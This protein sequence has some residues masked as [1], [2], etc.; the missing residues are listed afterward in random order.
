MRALSDLRLKIIAILSDDKGHSHGDISRLLGS[1]K[2]CDSTT[3]KKR[4]DWYDKG[5]LTK[6]LKPMVKL[7]I[8][9]L[10]NGYYYIILSKETFLYI[11]KRIKEDS[12]DFSRFFLE[13]EYVNNLIKTIGFKSVYSAINS[14]I[15]RGFRDI[16]TSALLNHLATIEEY[17]N[18]PKLIQEYFNSMENANEMAN[19]SEKFRQEQA[20]QAKY[21]P[22]FERMK[23]AARDKAR[24]YDGA[25]YDNKIGKI[26]ELET[27]R[28][29][30]IEGVR[31]YRKNLFDEFISIFAGRM[32][33]AEK[34]NP[35]IKYV[36]YDNYLS[37]FTAYPVNHP[38]EMMFSGY[39]SRLYEDVYLLDSK[40]IGLLLKRANLIFEN[41]SKFSRIYIGSRSNAEAAIRELIFNWNIA[42]AR[43]ETICSLLG[44]I[45]Y[46]PEKSC[47]HLVIEGKD[48]QIIDLKTDQ[49]LLGEFDMEKL[50]AGGLNK[51]F[52]EF[53]QTQ[54]MRPV[55][56]EHLGHG[57][58]KELVPI[59]TIISRIK[60][61]S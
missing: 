32:V 19:I 31:F 44:Q 29:L 35:I 53:D 42:C 2:K 57:W 59:E 14:Q 43:F 51:G 40:D 50:E 17:K 15:D 9:H 52:Y 13:S 21:N 23:V 24:T 54:F 56:I 27:L 37:P 1:N 7:K 12:M 30:G 33:N 3:K 22:A 28:D 18:L 34:C 39:F 46:D 58:K 47:F 6:A 26:D 61:S 36:E 20:R 10:K 55:L 45:G 16:A 60:N 11:I 41:F 49:R 38:I 48:F 8:I 25:P 4:H 5:N